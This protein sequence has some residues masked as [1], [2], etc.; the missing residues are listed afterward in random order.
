MMTSQFFRKRTYDQ[1]LPVSLSVIRVVAWGQDYVRERLIP[2]DPD[3]SC[4]GRWFCAFCTGKT[5]L[6]RK[7]EGHY[8][9]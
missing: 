2:H 1:V 8:Y 4:Y 3:R 6:R 7:D 5:A 9:A